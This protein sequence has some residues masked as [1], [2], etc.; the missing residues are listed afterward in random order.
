MIDVFTPFE[1]EGNGGQR[2]TGFVMPLTDPIVSADLMP[3]VSQMHQ[4]PASN[5]LLMIHGQM[6]ATLAEFDTRLMQMEKLRQ[7][8]LQLLDDQGV[9]GARLRVNISFDNTDASAPFWLQAVPLP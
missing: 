1:H 8:L 7:S 4:N 6:P 3:F 9:A 5:A 2:V